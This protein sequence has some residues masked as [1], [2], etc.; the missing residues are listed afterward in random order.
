MGPPKVGQ[1]TT[2]GTVVRE[3]FRVETQGVSETP[4]QAYEG[5]ADDY[6]S[7]GIQ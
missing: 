3:T 5:V 4:A 2:V 6:V 7:N 1:L